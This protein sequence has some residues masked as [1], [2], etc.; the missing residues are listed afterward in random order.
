MGTLMSA[1]FAG[2]YGSSKPIPKKEKTVQ[3]KKYKIAIPGYCKITAVINIGN[4][5]SN[6]TT[7]EYS[8]FINSKIPLIKN[9]PIVRAEIGIANKRNGYIHSLCKLVNFNS[10]SFN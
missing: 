9:S 2:K 6:S 10:F 8:N 4:I 5:K 1:A 7:L 3:L